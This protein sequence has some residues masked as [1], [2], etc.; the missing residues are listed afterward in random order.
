MDVIGKKFTLFIRI[1]HFPALVTSKRV[2]STRSIRFNNTRWFISIHL[3][4]YCQ[5]SG[6]Y[7]ILEPNSS[8]QPETLG[9]YIHGSRA[10]VER[11]S[12]FDVTAQFKFKQAPTARSDHLTH[13]F[14][15][16]SSNGYKYS[17]GT[18]NLA[19]IEVAFIFNFRLF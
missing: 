6:E 18:S 3:F 5:T 19:T 8:D 2:F 4:K 14:C 11:Y 17:Y 10:H 13:K 9:A 15:L 12:S 16:N 1:K 7:I